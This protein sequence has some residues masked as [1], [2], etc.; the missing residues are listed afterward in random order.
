MLCQGDFENMFDLCKKYWFYIKVILQ[1]SDCEVFM[2][3]RGAFWCENLHYI[4]IY[5]D[6]WR[7]NKNP[8]KLLK[9]FKKPIDKRKRLW[10]NNQVAAKNGRKNI[11]KPS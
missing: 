4:Y 1:G 10:Y 5:D 8:K 9:N 2:E 11:T 3:S 7:K 6:V